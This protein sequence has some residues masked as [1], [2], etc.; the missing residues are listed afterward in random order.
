MRSN[1]EVHSLKNNTF[2]AKVCLKKTV[3][4]KSVKCSNETNK[5]KLINELLMSYSRVKKN[6]DENESV[7]QSL[8]P[9]KVELS[10]R[11]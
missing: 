10:L 8:L 2:H 7:E 1:V 3:A 5:R 6:N 9:V 11:G 4:L